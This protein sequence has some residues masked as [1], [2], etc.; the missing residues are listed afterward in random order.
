MQMHHTLIA[1]SAACFMGLVAAPTHATLLAH[2]TFDEASG[3][4]V[5]DSAGTVDGTATDVSFVA[6]TAGVS[7]SG[8]G[9]A[10]VFNGFTS[11]VSFGE[12]DIFDLGTDDFTIAGWFKA[13]ENTGEGVFANRPVFQNINY[14]GGGWVFE[15]GRNDRSYAGEIFFTVGGGSGTIFGQTQV[16]SDT[17]V[18]DGLWHWVA[19][20]NTGG[21]T[22]M[23]ID[24]L[25]QVDTGEL[26]SGTSTATSPIGT[27]AQ[28]GARGLAQQPFEGNLDDWRIYDHSLSG[29]LD[30]S[31]YLASGE[32]FD[33]WQI[34]AAPALTGDLDGDGFV[35]IADLNLVLG[36]WNQNVTP[37]DD[38][39]GDPSGDGF[40]G[41]EDLNTVLGNW[42]AG[43]PPSAS[44]VP[45]P[46]SLALVGLGGLSAL[47]RR[48]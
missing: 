20:T 23:Y 14:A 3:T 13:P 45:E 1:A 41:I 37:G 9:N 46:A 25:L 11:E 36:N 40:V 28:L 27:V 44:A 31:N 7:G 15:I 32:L 38:L 42:N 22:A 21:D 8:L 30:G 4:T 6:S 35:G 43:T 2:Y 19:V 5:A 29:T 33:I 18:D 12:P 26:V 48:R 17:R 39:S 10:G 24:G 16:F 47:R 34:G